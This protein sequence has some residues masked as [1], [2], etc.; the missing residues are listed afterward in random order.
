MIANSDYVARR[1]QRVWGRRA[2]VIYPPVDVKHF[3]S[4]LHH[5]EREGYLVVSELVPYKRVDLAVTTATQYGLP[6]TVVGDGVERQRLQSL[7]GPTVN[8]VGA[9]SDRNVLRTHYA[10]A[11]ALLFC[12]VEGFGIVPVEAMAAGCPVVAFADGGVIE[13]VC[14]SGRHVAGVYFT[15]PSAASL[16]D[17]IDRLEIEVKN[18]NCKP[19][20]FLPKLV[21]FAAHVSAMRGLTC[22]FVIVTSVIVTAIYISAVSAFSVAYS[23]NTTLRTLPLAVS[24]NSVVWYQVVGILNL[25]R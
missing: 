7:A 20:R 5:G 12:G 25:A 10:R 17:A 14:A 13:S 23:R 16:K 21:N 22:C 2:K 4:D 1:I 24:G 15:T 9:I 19:V 3:E 6:L 8:F 11:R 18:Q